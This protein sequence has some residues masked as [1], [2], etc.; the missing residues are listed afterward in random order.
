MKSGMVC[1]I[2]GLLLLA[3]SNAFAWR[4]VKENSDQNSKIKAMQIVDDRLIIITANGVIDIKIDQLEQLLP[5]NKTITV[6]P[7][8][9]TQATPTPLPPP[10]ITPAAPAPTAKPAPELPAD[11]PI[12]DRVMA[13]LNNGSAQWYVFSGK[14]YGFKI[15][16]QKNVQTFDDGAIFRGVTVDKRL[17]LQDLKGN[18]YEPTWQFSFDFTKFVLP[19]DPYVKKTL[20]NIDRLKATIVEKEK[21]IQANRDLTLIYLQQ[22]VELLKNRSYTLTQLLDTHGNTNLSVISNEDI[23]ANS[24]LVY[25]EL[26]TR[27]SRLENIN[28]VLIKDVSNLKKALQTAVDQYNLFRD[29]LIQAQKQFNATVVR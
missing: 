9:D 7:A 27:I 15:M 29:R 25:S 4:I 23:D 16:N 8:K 17:Y 12:A 13:A 3:S 19:A 5:V 2:A 20:A 24:L 18:V 1:G 21:E 26:R 10:A 11:A 14:P 22:I 6:T 28:H